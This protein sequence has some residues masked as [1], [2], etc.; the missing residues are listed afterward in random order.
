MTD[1]TK[2]LPDQLKTP[3]R[4]ALV[5]RGVIA[6]AFMQRKRL[7]THLV[8]RD[9]RSLCGAL[10]PTGLVSDMTIYADEKQTCTKCLKAF[11]ADGGR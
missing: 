1:D 8:G 4:V 3:F 7:V 5:K 2:V 9:Q 6:A 11:R 10:R